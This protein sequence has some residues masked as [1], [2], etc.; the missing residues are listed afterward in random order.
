MGLDQSSP[1]RAGQALGELESVQA[2]AGPSAGGAAA[3]SVRDQW[4][5][6]VAKIKASDMATIAQ[7]LAYA[8][9][10]IDQLPPN[11]QTGT[12]KTA[13]IALLHHIT[14]HGDAERLRLLARARLEQ[15]RVDV[16]RQDL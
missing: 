8:I 14:P 16:V 11:W 4:L 12:D 15:R 9:E 6:R 2:A 5:E 10:A 3:L 13:M 1:W 7:A